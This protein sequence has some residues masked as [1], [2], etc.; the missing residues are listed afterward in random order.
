MLTQRAE[1]MP[2]HAGQI[3]F[4][5][6]RVEP[7]RLTAVETAL[8]ETEEEVGLERRYVEP[9]GVIEPTRPAPAIAS[10]RSSAC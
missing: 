8:R 9:I 3:A 6:G 2:T 4:P 1:N 10:R 7:G 5:G